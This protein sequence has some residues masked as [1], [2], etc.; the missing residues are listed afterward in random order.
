MTQHDEGTWLLELDEKRS[1]HELTT[2]QP[3]S[4]DD[5]AKTRRYQARQTMAQAIRDVHEY[6]RL[7]LQQNLL[8]RYL[9]LVLLYVGLNVALLGANFASQDFIEQH[10]YQT[11]HMISF[12]GVFG[13]TLLEAHVLIA[14]GIVSW[15]HRLQ[16]ILI[17]FNVMASFATAVL[18]SIDPQVYEVPAHY[19]EYSVQILISCVNILFLQTTTSTG[20][21]I[22]RRRFE[23]A[24]A[25]VVLGLSIATL[26]VYATGA[27]RSAHFCEFINEIFNGLFTLFFAAF[28]YEDVHGQLE[29]QYAGMQALKQ[30]EI[31]D[32]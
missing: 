26:I 24:V 25:I 13:F 23:L 14:T 30:Y 12:W 6:E 17:L 31:F 22:I 28:C 8:L 18:F 7:N 10:Y 27:E 29:Q 16:T 32:L 4:L 20:T 15:P 9:F 5:D 1:Y 21:L 11:F 3:C 2:S 19:M